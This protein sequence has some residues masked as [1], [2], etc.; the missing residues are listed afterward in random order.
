[1]KTILAYGGGVDSTAILCLILTGEIEAPDAVVFADPGAEFSETYATVRLAE[2]LCSAHGIDFETVRHERDTILS[3]LERN[4]NLPVMP[5]GPHVCSLK[6]KGEPMQKWAEA[7][8]PGEPITWLVGIEPEESR[9]AKRFTPPKGSTHLFR[10][11]LIEQRITRTDC[12][13]IIAEV[14]QAP[15]RK[16]SCFFCPFM[17]KAEIAALVGSPEWET[18][19]TIEN[20]FREASPEKHQRWIDAGKPMHGSRAPAGM[21]RKDAWQDGARLF[22]KS[23]NGK[24]LTIEEWESEIA[25][26]AQ[27]SLFDADANAALTV[28]TNHTK[29]T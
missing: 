26:P 6:F 7:T 14:W 15:V 3:W 21:W 4:S 11:P 25:N 19:K 9:R 13:Q 5:G 2:R 23:H 27:G 12:I 28:R 8:Y 24:R 18:A 29:R 10:Y 17:C 1:M 16:S 20:R 22:S